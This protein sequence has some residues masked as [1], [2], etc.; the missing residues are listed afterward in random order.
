[1]KVALGAKQAGRLGDEWVGQFGSFFIVG[2]DESMGNLM[3]SWE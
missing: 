1:M 3:V 2:F